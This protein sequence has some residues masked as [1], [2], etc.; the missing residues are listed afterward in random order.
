M[1]A[2]DDVGARFSGN[3]Y[4]TS[5]SHDFELAGSGRYETRLTM[6]RAAS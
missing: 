5:A 1:V 6:R 3:Y 2:I 4:V